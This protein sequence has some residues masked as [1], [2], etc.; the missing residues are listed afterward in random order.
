MYG[1]E[2]LG[3]SLYRGKHVRVGWIGGVCAGMN[4]CGVSM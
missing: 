1:V 4:V 2:V 3:V